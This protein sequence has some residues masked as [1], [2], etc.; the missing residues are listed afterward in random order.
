MSAGEHYH[1]ELIKPDTVLETGKTSL[2]QGGKMWKGPGARQNTAFRDLEE[3]CVPGARTC[4]EGDTDE[5]HSTQTGFITVLKHLN[6]LER[7]LGVTEGLS[8]RE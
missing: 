7:T 6:A 1:P 4:M 3:L 5:D 8:G 2:S